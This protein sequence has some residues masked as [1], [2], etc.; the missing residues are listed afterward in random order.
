MS[1]TGGIDVFTS[2]A[3]QKQV[4]VLNKQKI[5][6]EKAQS[7]SPAQ[8][9][10]GKL[11]SNIKPSLG[12]SANQSA[13]KESYQQRPNRGQVRCTYNEG[14]SKVTGA[15]NPK[16]QFKVELEDFPHKLAYWQNPIKDY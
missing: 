15:Q 6:S 8:S 5:E 14:V 7:P 3:Q 4:K 2:L 13:L 9:K 12:G 1:I 11:Q 16:G 10:A